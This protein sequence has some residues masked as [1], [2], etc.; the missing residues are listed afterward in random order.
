MARSPMKKRRPK[1]E[2]ATM[3]T[4]ERRQFVA[5]LPCAACGIVG[6]SANAHLLGT[7]G[8]G[9]KRSADTIGP[10]CADRSGVTGCHTLY[11]A[12]PWTFRERFPDFDP[13]WVAMQ[14]ERRWQQ[15]L[16]A[17][18]PVGTILPRVLAD[19]LQRSKDGAA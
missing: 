19:V 9:R 10:L 8:M 18:E 11:D 16:R 4:R 5:T 13:E 14:T 12:F 6:Y 2:A 17:P 7:G 3:G 15:S 1:H